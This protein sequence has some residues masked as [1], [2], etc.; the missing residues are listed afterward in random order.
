MFINLTY[1]IHLYSYS[2]IN[3]KLMHHNDDDTCRHARF[4]ITAFSL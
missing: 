2:I 3:I 4:S 1:G